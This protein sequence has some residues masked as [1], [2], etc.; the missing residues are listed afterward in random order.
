MN[1]LHEQGMQEVSELQTEKD[2]VEKFSIA[3]NPENKREGIVYFPADTSIDQDRESILRIILG[4]TKEFP[5]AFPGPSVKLDI[6]KEQP[7]STYPVLAH[8]TLSE[9]SLVFND[10]RI[11][12][13]HVG[14]KKSVSGGNILS[15]ST[16]AKRKDDSGNA[17]EGYLPRFREMVPVTLEYFQRL[18]YSIDEIES[19]WPIEQ[20]GVSTNYEQFYQGIREGLSPLEAAKQTLMGRIYDA[21]QF[22]KVEVLNTPESIEHKEAVAV[23]FRK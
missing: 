9:D 19:L 6:C 1:E 13:C 22:T 10:D 16:I 15:F 14:R 2:S 8:L 23:R 12:F 11:G 17:I 7:D 20:L 5:V 21:N 4:K 18:G 3:L